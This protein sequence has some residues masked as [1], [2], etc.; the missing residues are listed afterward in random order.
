MKT[1]ANYGQQSVCACMQAINSRAEA[2]D[3]EQLARASYACILSR[4]ASIFACMQVVM[5][6]HPLSA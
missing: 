2:D 3:L 1:K 6:E 5:F 4:C